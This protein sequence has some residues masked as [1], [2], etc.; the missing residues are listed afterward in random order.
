MAENHRGVA[1]VPVAV[2]DLDADISVVG[3]ILAVE[4]VGGKGGIV[5]L[6]KPVR[7]LHDPA[8]IDAGMVGDHVAGQPD[9][10]PQRSFPQVVERLP[11]AQIGG[12]FVVVERIGRS[13]GLG[14]AA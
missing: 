12:D 8:G 5:G 13:D 10:A 14:I 1:L 4:L 11:A 9:A 3:E 7:M 2:L 6:D